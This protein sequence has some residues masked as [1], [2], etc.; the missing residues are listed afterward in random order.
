[1][2][3]Y[4]VEFEL[5]PLDEERLVLERGCG[6]TAYDKD[7][8]LALLQER[9]FGGRPLPPVRRII[10]DIDI[11]TLD[12][13]HVLPNMDLPFARGVWFPKGFYD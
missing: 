5:D 11:S 1:M 8:A 6:V 2:H 10:E 3:R 7:D 9:V 12:S 4:W 13:G